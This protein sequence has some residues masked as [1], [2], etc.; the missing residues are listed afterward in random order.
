VFFYL[1]THHDF[2]LEEVCSNFL[3]SPCDRIISRSFTLAFRGLQLETADGND[4]QKSGK[5]SKFG[6]Y[7]FTFGNQHIVEEAASFSAVLALQSMLAYD[8]PLRAIEKYGL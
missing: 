5:K 7:L 2:I 6:E 3:C 8:R 4:F 1:Q